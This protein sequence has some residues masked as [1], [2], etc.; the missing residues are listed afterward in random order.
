MRWRLSGCYRLLAGIENTSGPVLASGIV[1]GA[2][3]FSSMQFF[4]TNVLG[5]QPD[6]N[7]PLNGDLTIFIVV[8]KSSAANTFGFVTTKCGGYNAANSNL[9]GSAI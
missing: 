5:I 3:T 2:S 9:S 4:N 1:N 8:D 7:N 6:P